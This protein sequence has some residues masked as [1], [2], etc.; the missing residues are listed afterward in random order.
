M[1][2]GAIVPEVGGRKSEIGGDPGASAPE[3][4]GTV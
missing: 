3:A 1:R 4:G 2:G